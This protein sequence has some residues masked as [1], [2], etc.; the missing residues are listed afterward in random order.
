MPIGELH[1]PDGKT[2]SIKVDG[3]SD[4]NKYVKE[5]RLNGKLLPYR[6]LSYKEIMQGGTLEYVMTN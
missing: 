4:D 6:S 2:F 5:I 1:L 3:L